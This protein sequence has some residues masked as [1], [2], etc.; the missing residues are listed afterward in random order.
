M[1]APVDFAGLISVLEQTVAQ[2]LAK[3][4]TFARPFLPSRFDFPVSGF[5]PCHHVDMRSSEIPFSLCW[6]LEIS[7]ASPDGWKTE[8]NQDQHGGLVKP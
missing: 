4:Q 5:Y 2:R 6:R 7:G 8:S 1:R 3:G